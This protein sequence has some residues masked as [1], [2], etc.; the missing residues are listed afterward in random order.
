[1]KE[2]IMEMYKFERSFLA[3]LLLPSIITDEIYFKM[4]SKKESASNS[5]TKYNYP[6]LISFKP[7][8]YNKFV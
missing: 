6:R 3:F 8:E 1:M 4:H 5:I 2:I 7:S